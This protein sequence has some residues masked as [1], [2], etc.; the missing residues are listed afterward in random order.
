MRIFQRRSIT[1]ISIPRFPALTH[2]QHFFLVLN[3]EHEAPAARHL[4]PPEFESS[5]FTSGSKVFFCVFDP[6][7]ARL[8][9]SLDTSDRV[10]ESSSASTR[11]RFESERINRI[12]PL[13]SILLSFSQ[14]SS[15]ATDFMSIPAHASSMFAFRQLAEHL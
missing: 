8:S 7:R 5:L 15:A 10:H 13:C 14:A 6:L 11:I 1:D 9:S 3:V 4:P 12:L 2:S